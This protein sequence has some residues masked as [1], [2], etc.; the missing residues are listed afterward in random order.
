MVVANT[1]EPTEGGE[2]RGKERGEDDK[3]RGG[4]GLI[5]DRVDVGV[6]ITTEADSKSD[7]N[8][9]REAPTMMR[10]RSNT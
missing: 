6:I 2:A 3:K 9:E 8:E 5:K 1:G 7:E 10:C 4:V